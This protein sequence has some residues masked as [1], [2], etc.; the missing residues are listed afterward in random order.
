MK[1]ITLDQA[2]DHVKAD[3]DDDELLTVY[4]NAAEAACARLANRNLY[5]AT[6]DLNAA[7][8]TISATMLAAYAAYDAAV[9][10][11][12][13]QDDDRMKVMMLA[14]AQVALN[15]ATNQV[16]AIV[17]GLALDV[18]ADASGQPVGD[19][20]VL[21]ILMTVGHMYRNR[22]SVVTG[23][24]AAAVE[25]PMSAQNIM[26]MHRWIGPL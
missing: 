9:L 23:Q 25:V 20:I 15:N 12:D 8:A 2:R 10:D 11:A 13:A 18:A 3:G 1:L 4:C 5:P 6:A 17:H 7:V 24:G 14:A 21:A 19:D 22:E 26:A 16:D